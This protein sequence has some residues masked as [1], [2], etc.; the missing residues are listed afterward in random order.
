MLP[1]IVLFLCIMYTPPGY[2]WLDYTLLAGIGLFIY[3]VINLIVIMA[4]D[5]TSKKAIGAAAGFIGLL[6]Y[7]G[8]TYQDKKIGNMLE[9]YKK[10]GTVEHAW[11]LVFWWIVICSA[12]A[13]V[14][15]A[16]T[17]NHKTSVQVESAEGVAV[18]S[19]LAEV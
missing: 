6:G 14:L 12:I 18:E 5:I 11:H 16:L 4:L 15:L 7:L 19:D 10:I 3:P 2:L 9:H 17:W 13:A 1:I 8:R